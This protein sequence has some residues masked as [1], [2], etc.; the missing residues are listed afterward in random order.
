MIVFRLPQ[1]LLQKIDFVFGS[2]DSAFRLLHKSVQHVHGIRK[3]NCV[4]GAIAVALA[5]F[6]DF[7][8]CGA[9]ETFE[10]LGGRMLVAPLREK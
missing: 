4:D 5:I 3:A 8:N 7:E 10:R 1:T 6:H 2:L 9:T